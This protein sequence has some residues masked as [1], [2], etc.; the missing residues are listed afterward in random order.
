MQ[1]N[2]VFGSDFTA[3]QLRSFVK[4]HKITCGRNGRFVHN[5]KNWNSGTKGMC[6]PN[7]GSFRAGQ[8][9]P[10]LKPIGH[11][12]IDTTGFILVKI[13]EKNPYT[14]A[15]ARY[16]HKHVVVWEQHNGPVPRGMAVMFLDSDTLNCDISNL[17]LITRAELLAL[18]R[19][20]YKQTP[21]VIKPTLLAVCR[22][23]VKARH[24]LKR[25]SVKGAS[26]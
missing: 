5:R 7:S 23:E 14:G 9:P 21:G 4:N 16:K 13:A 8:T 19:S 2:E 11:E 10:N 6:K 18:N 20:G 26:P 24:R 3:G 12:R 15:P 17:A 1:L 22:V 25:Q